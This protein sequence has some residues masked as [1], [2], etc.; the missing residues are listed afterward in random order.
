MASIFRVHT[1]RVVDGQRLKTLSKKWY[2]NVPQIDGSLRR[3]ALSANKTAAQSMLVELLKRAELAK[4]GVVNAFEDSARKLLADHLADFRRSMQA[5]GSTATHV[6]LVIQRATAVIDGCGF[7]RIAD[8]SASRVADF[9]HGLR[10]SIQS[11]NH[12]LRAVKQFCRWLVSDRRAAENVLQHLATGNVSAGRKLERRELS[13]AEIEALLNAARDGKPVHGLRG[14]ER[15]MLYSVALQTGL[16][17]AELASLKPSHFDL[18]SQPATV[19]IDAANEKA[20]RG[21]TL[22]IPGS[23]ADLLRPWLASMART[24]PLWPGKWAAAKRGSKLMQHDLE[25]ARAAWVRSCS[26]PVEQAQRE[27]D[28]DFLR[29]RDSDGLQAD[30]H[31]LRHTFLSRLGRAG[32]SAKVMQRL[33]RHSTVELTIG[34]YT[35]AGLHDLAGAVDLLPELTPT[36]AVAPLHATGTEN[37]CTVACTEFAQTGDIPGSLVITPDTFNRPETEPKECENPRENRVFPRI[38]AERAGFEPT[39]Q[40]TPHSGLANRCIK[41]LCHLS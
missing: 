29:Y 17:A 13:Q 40:V 22:P 10:L 31:S 4:M 2:A 27:G 26:T 34:R 3:M 9:I 28:Q 33:A 7:K 16:R 23:L 14:F 37:V 19:R 24:A 5:S 38:S 11:K 32:V 1:T 12:Y 15:Y 39:V 35:H 18:A 21:D 36:P 41:P 25:S 6:A 30:F 8:I 20:R